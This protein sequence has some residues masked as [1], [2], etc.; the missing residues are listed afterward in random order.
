MKINN[1]PVCPFTVCWQTKYFPTSAHWFFN[2]SALAPAVLPVT[3]H[4]PWY[5]HKGPYT[6][7]AAGAACAR[8]HVSVNTSSAQKRKKHL[9][10]FC[11]HYDHNLAWR[12]S[13]LRVGCATCYRAIFRRSTRSSWRFARASPFESSAMLTSVEATFTV[14]TQVVTFPSLTLDCG[15]TLMNVD[16]A[17]ET[18]G[19]LNAA[20]TNAILVLHAFSGDAHAAGISKQTGQPGWWSPMIGSGLAFDTDR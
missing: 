14:E 5:S 15:V 6:G 20:R 11:P 3:C 7:S 4:V 16:V 18:Y 19:T 12:P 13:Q 2:S 8:E 9:P 10:A 1:A 17:Y